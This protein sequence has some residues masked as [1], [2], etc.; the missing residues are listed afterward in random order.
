MF[1]P[2]CMCL[3]HFGLTAL[4]FVLSALLQNIAYCPKSTNIRIPSFLLPQGVAGKSVGQQ[5]FR[6]VTLYSALI[7]CLCV[8]DS[9]FCYGE[10]FIRS[11]AWH[12]F[13]P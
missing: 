3:C 6:H 13:R 8:L 1:V 10:N 9:G 4:M 12:Q 2:Y 7:S 11:I 5:V